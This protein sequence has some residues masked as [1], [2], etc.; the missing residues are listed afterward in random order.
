MQ[1]FIARLQGA[2]SFFYRDVSMI[3]H[4]YIIRPA[5]YNVKRHGHNIDQIKL[6]D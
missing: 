1:G 5:P 6:P 2:E 4:R 3:V